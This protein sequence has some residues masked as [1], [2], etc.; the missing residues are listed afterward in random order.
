MPEAGDASLP[1]CTHQR[2]PAWLHLQLAVVTGQFSLFKGDRDVR[3]EVPEEQPLLPA[4]RNDAA[5]RT[6]HCTH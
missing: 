6:P 1:R 2:Q 5:F 3:Y 4:Q